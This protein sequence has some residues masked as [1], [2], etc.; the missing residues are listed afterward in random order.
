MNHQNS[1]PNPEF[2]AH[3]RDLDVLI[4]Q[5]VAL[6][7]HL[8]PY[9]VSG[10][11]M[12]LLALD[13]LGCSGYSDIQAESD[14]GSKTPLS[15]LSDGIQIGCGCTPGK[16]NLRITSWCRPRVWFADQ[17]GRT[18]TIEIRPEVTASFREQSIEQASQHVKMLPLEEL[19][20]W[21]APSS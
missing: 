9:L 15:C 18:V 4:S 5:G 16:G 8:G 20:L 19:F 1:G 7:G 21:N 17:N 11:R 13:L 14:A 6:H 12:G 2:V 3:G 10:I